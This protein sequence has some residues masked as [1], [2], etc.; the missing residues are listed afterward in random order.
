MTG[1]QLLCWFVVHIL[2]GQWLLVEE[3]AEYSAVRRGTRVLGGK[4]NQMSVGTVLL[5]LALWEPY[6]LHLVL[7]QH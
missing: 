6:F 2:V 3:I 5:Q 1:L 7:S 4:Y